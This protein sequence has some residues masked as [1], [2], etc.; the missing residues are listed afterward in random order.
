MTFSFTS[1]RLG[2]LLLNSNLEVKGVFEK[3]QAGSPYSEYHKLIEKYD[4]RKDSNGGMMHHKVFIIDKKIVITGSYN[5]T[6]NGNEN[7]DENVLIIH[8]KVIAKKY[9]EEFEKIYN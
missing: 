2:E 8:S 3:S 1:D 9:L 7:N 6:K 5:P 4:V